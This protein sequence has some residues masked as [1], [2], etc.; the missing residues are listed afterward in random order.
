M[1]EGTP[2]EL[3]AAASP[4]DHAREI[5][6]HWFDELSEPLRCYLIHFGASTHQAE[7]AIQETFLRLHAIRRDKPAFANVRAWTFQVARNFLRDEWKSA[8]VRRTVSIDDPGNDV[9]Q[10]PDSGRSP[11]Q[12]FLGEEQSRR[13]RAAI[14]NLAP[15]ERECIFLRTS[16][17]KYRE[18][19]EV[20]GISLGT[21]CNLA[22][23]AS[24]RLKEDLS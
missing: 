5:V 13:L 10:F 8:H 14:N 9:S 15:Q 21:V 1:A 12:A 22:T 17:L 24:E 20:M 6:L 3:E 4:P 16:G 7:D 18:I 2:A 19:A 11:E 23:R